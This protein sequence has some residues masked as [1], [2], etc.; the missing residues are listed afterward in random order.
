M[1]TGDKATRIA[2]AM[3]EGLNCLGVFLCGPALRRMRAEAPQLLRRWETDY[4]PT[5]R[6][7]AAGVR[8]SNRAKLDSALS[9]ISSAAITG[10]D[11]DAPEQLAALRRAI[12]EAILAFEFPMP[13]LTPAEAAICELHG[14]ACPMLE[15]A[16]Q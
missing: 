12:R 8:R 16:Y 14:S 7:A 10:V 5:F 2:Q 4:A 9:R 6:E 11:L 15:G 13:D 3:G 1:D